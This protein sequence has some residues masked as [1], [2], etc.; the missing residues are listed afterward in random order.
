MSF[1]IE[2]QGTLLGKTSSGKSEVSDEKFYPMK[3]FHRRTIFLH[4][5][6]IS[7][8][9]AKMGYF[10]TSKRQCKNGQKMK[11]G[12]LIWSNLP[13]KIK[14]S[15][16]VFGLK[17]KVKIWKY[18]LRIF[19]LKVISLKTVFTLLLAL[20]CIFPSWNLLASAAFVYQRY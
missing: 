7:W 16:S 5:H 10:F 4:K 11:R 17:T 15:N 3:N 9:Q 2:R 6:I 1:I 13:V 20:F 12:S 18:W 8:K 14:S 19:N